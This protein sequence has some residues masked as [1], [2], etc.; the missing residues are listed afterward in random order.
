MGIWIYGFVDAI[1]ADKDAVRT[2]PKAV[3]VLI[4]LLFPIIGCLL[5]LAFGRPR[6]AADRGRTA[7]S[8]FHAPDDDEDFL[9][10]LEQKERRMRESRQK[11]N[12]GDTEDGSS[13]NN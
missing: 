5:W 8:G 4:T 9:R 3:W 6:T 11:K 7:S 1:R 10:F 13:T 2:M 12:P